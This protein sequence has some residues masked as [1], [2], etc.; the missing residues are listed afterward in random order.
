MAALA[1]MVRRYPPDWENAETW[2]NGNGG[3]FLATLLGRGVQ[4]LRPGDTKVSVVRTL[5][6]DVTLDGDVVPGSMHLIE[7]AGRDL[8]ATQFKDYVDQWQAGD[9]GDTPLLVAE[10]T[11]GYSS[12]GAFF[13]QPGRAPIRTRMVL[14][15]YNG[16]GKDGSPDMICYESIVYEWMCGEALGPIYGSD[17][18]WVGFPKHTCVYVNS[19][20]GG[21]SGSGG[22]GG[23][24]NPGNGGSGGGGGSNGDSKNPV[25]DE[26]EELKYTLSCPESVVRGAVA[27]CRIIFSNNADGSKELAF[28][29]TSSLGA[30]NT[31]VSWEGTA[32]DDV[33]ISVSIS[34]W[35]DKAE[36]SVTNRTW[37][38]P[39][40]LDAA[41]VKYKVLPP[42]IAGKYSVTQTLA[43]GAGTGPW[44]G[45][46]Y[47]RSAP[48]FSGELY[49]SIDYAPKSKVSTVPAYP[50]SYESLSSAGKAACPRG[51]FITDRRIRYR[52]LNY[53]CGTS[54]GWTNMHAQTLRHEEEHQAGANRCLRSTTTSNFFAKLEQFTGSASEANT[55]FKGDTGMWKECLRK[56]DKS[57]K[58]AARPTTSFVPFFRYVGENWIYR[59]RTGGVHSGV[60]GC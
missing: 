16:A 13:Y 19:G 30:K 33:T 42:G 53:K 8:D 46:Y 5:V 45:R 43:P 35:S 6:A 18:V 51:Q 57:M 52:D 54:I 4:D 37:K 25:D 50:F 34:N 24:D 23:R 58:Y 28:K 2:D 20:G 7:F 40:S 22:G 31:G 1:E 29:W 56:F 15:R 38:S 44:S 59:I 9:F 60:P 12:T 21:G 14:R 48:T 55:Q 36:I 11:I 26:D 49:I 41:D 17:C 3:Y 32:T 39:P 47:V 27:N 10:Y